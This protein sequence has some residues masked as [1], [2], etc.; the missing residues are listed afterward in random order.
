MAREKTLDEQRLKVLEQISGISA[1]RK[2]VVSSYTVPYK[3]KDGADKLNGPYFVL[4]KKSPGGKTVGEK[5]KPGQV[6]KMKACA[7][8][9]KRFQQLSDQYASICEQAAKDTMGAEADA[10][11]NE[12][13]KKNGKL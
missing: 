8:N 10:L 2:G 3:S 6:E 4:T 9:Y 1:M 11:K 5:I 12:R 13:A 7:D